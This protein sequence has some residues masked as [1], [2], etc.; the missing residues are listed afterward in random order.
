[1][2]ET[3]E[4]LEAVKPKTANPAPLGLLGFGMTTVL[5]NLH[6]DGI[7]GLSVMI[8]AMGFAAG[9][10]AQIVAG[11]FEM[12]L[13]NTFGGTAFI[14]YGSFWWSLIII[15]LNPGNMIDSA[16][17][18]SMGFYL[19]LWGIFSLFMFICTLRHNRIMQIIFS[20]LTV[21]FFGLALHDFTGIA[22]IGVVSGAIGI[23]CGASAIYCAMGQMLKEEYGREILKLG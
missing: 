14:A 17:T 22:A 10:F 6:N 2:E 13:G 16:D 15:W 21:L 8:V 7:I 9:G 20:S 1:M 4:K 11:I 23:F 5:L 18:K 3:K 12:R 19:L